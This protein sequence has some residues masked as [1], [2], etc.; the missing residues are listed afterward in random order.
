MEY[1]FHGTSKKETQLSGKS[2]VSA[3]SIIH[4]CILQHLTFHMEKVFSGHLD[5]VLPP[6]SLV[7]ADRLY[8]W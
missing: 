7:L 1:R 6:K 5:W 3:T 4:F 2:Y 8:D